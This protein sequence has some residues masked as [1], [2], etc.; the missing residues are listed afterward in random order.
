MADDAI[1]RIA[2]RPKDACVA[3]GIG[4]TKLYELIKAG[5]LRSKK[6]DNCTLISADSVRALIDA[7]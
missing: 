3:L 7:E 4:R 2:Y 5:L 6:V 1:E